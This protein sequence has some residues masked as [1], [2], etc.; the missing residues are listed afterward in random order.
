MFIGVWQFCSI[1]F[2]FGR[3][4]GLSVVLRSANS[5]YFIIHYSLF[6]IHLLWRFTG[7]YCP[8]RA[9]GHISRLFFPIVLTTQ[10]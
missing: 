1:C 6:I 10:L 4:F 3:Q 8:S 7:Y 2:C 9:H 5:L